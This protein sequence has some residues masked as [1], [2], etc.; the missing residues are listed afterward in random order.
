[1][2]ETFL[3]Y[4]AL[5]SFLVRLMQI[6][7]LHGPTLND[8]GVLSFN[9]VTSPDLLQLNYQR[10]LLPPKKYLLP[11]Q[12]PILHYAPTEGYT[13]AKTPGDEILL[14]GL[15]P[16]DLAGIAYLDR[17]FLDDRPDP[18]Y[19]SRRERLVLVGISCESDEYCFCGDVGVCPTAAAVPFDLFLS[20]QDSGFRIR[21]GSRRGEEIISWAADIVGTAGAET[22]PAEAAETARRICHAVGKRRMFEGSTLWDD[23]AG[24]CLSCGAC[25]LCCPTCYCVD[26]REYGAIDGQTGERVQEWDNCLFKA[27][28]EIAGGINFRKTRQERFHYRF[29]HKYYGFGPLRDV[30]SCVGCGRCRAVCPV[31]IDLLE[32]F[33]EEPA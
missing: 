20:R 2:A 25:S 28:G 8:L 22:R 6:G 3:T 11:P 7:T 24:R 27:H 4:N 31:G 29:L 23:F 5:G 26:V 14:F 30:I 33:G 17:V 32:L 16:C 1:M 15:H 13:P 19:A 21:T 12:S 18:L 10:T 9:P